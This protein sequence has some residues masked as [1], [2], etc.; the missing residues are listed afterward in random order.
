MNDELRALNEKVTC[1]GPD[2][3]LRP[4]T[5]QLTNMFSIAASHFYALYLTGNIQ[6]A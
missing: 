1:A 5:R 3:F 6:N 4:Y 2:G